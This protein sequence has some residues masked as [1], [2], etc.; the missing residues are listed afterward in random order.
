MGPFFWDTVD[1]C[2]LTQCEVNDMA[3]M[4]NPRCKKPPQTKIY[5]IDH[6][7]IYHRIGNLIS[8]LAVRYGHSDSYPICVLLCPLRCGQSISYVVLLYFEFKERQIDKSAS[9]SQ[10]WQWTDGC[11]WK[12]AFDLQTFSELTTR[13]M[14]QVSG[15]PPLS[16]DIVLREIGVNDSEW[17]DNQMDDLQA[18]WPSLPTVG[19]IGN[20]NYLNLLL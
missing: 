20:N 12:S 8:V 13:T 17:T 5:S 2:L 18:L 1:M 6:R 7:T 9:M 11:C 3:L 10:H 14:S 4:N 15:N 19:S 16:R